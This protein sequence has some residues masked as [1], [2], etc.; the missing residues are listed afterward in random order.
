MIFPENVNGQVGTG[1]DFLHRAG[2]AGRTQK[3]VS[4]VTPGFPGGLVHLFADVG[5]IFGHTGYDF[6][7]DHLITFPDKR[8]GTRRCRADGYVR[9]KYWHSQSG[10]G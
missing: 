10:S 5:Y 7:T 4:R 6:L 2:L 8:H 1:A 9:T 3:D